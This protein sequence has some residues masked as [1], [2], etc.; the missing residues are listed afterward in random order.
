[1]APGI[2]RVGMALA[3]AVSVNVGLE[4]PARADHRDFSID[5]QSGANLV[6]LWI[7]PSS[8]SDWEEEMLKGQVIRPGRRRK[9]TFTDRYAA[10]ECLFDLKYVDANLDSW[11][12]N[13][14]DLCKV[15]ELT[16]TRQGERVVGSWR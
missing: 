1:M 16:L 7:S 4:L 14:V 6:K 2:W 10:Q 15:S 12:F 3:L 9:I 8:S 5:N 11:T 13:K